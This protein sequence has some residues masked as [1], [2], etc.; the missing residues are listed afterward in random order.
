M[1]QAVGTY[2]IRPN[3]YLDVRVYTNNGERLIDPNGELGFGSP[4]GAQGT[5]RATQ[6]PQRGAQGGSGTPSASDY[7]VQ[8]DGTVVL[9]VVSRVAVAGLTSQ[10]ADS[11]LQLRYEKFYRGVFVQTRVTNNRVFVLGTP[12]GQVIPVNN[13]NMN[14]VEVLAYV[15]GING[16]AGGANSV[17]GNASNIRL[18]RPTPN[19]DLKNAQVQIVNLNTIEG[20]RRASLRVQPNDI[21]YIEPSRRSAF[22]QSL[23]DAAPLFSLIGVT[24]SLTAVTVSIINQIK[25]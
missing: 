16:G 20:M 5:T 1:N 6:T 14:L 11:L 8:P 25:Q 2:R 9:P 4:G 13:E 23:Q 22:I 3:D 10:Q 21:I 24:I 18:I 7:L 15:G 19:G 17:G 12:G